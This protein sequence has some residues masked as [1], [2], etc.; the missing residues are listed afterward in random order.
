[1]PTVNSEG[2]IEVLARRPALRF[3][4]DLWA[5][6]DDCPALGRIVVLLLV[7]VLRAREAGHGAAPSWTHGRRG[8]SKGLACLWLPLAV[9][10]GSTP[11][12]GGRRREGKKKNNEECGRRA[13]APPRRASPDLATPRHPRRRMELGLGLGLIGVAEGGVVGP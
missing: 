9:G 8:R 7:C 4:G 10:E 2:K 11:C 13:C 12:P 6:S 5:G 3:L 1:M